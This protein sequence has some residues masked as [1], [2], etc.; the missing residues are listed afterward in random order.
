MVGLFEL[1]L[2]CNLKLSISL[3]I[4]YFVVVMLGFWWQILDTSYLNVGW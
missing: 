2:V 4:Y 3:Q 1:F